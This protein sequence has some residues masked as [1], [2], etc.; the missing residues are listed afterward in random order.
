MSIK[1]VTTDILKD[2]VKSAYLDSNKT[3]N[4]IAVIFT[5]SLDKTDDEI[6]TAFPEHKTTIFSSRSHPITEEILKAISKGHLIFLFVDDIL[7]N[8][9][10]KFL[11]RIKDAGVVDQVAQN[12]TVTP[13]KMPESQLI[14]IIGNRDTLEKQHGNLVNLGGNFLDLI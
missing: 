14:F 1:N 8:E 9:S 4:Q 13:K 7:D 3:I 5:Q 11:K 10:F 2:F 6:N 12:G